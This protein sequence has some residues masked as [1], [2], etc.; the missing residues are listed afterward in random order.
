MRRTG[1]PDGRRRRRRPHDRARS[2]RCG[3]TGSDRSTPI[4]ARSCRVPASS[5]CVA[6]PPR[7]G[8]R[9]RCRHWA[10][11][12]C[13]CARHRRVA[14]AEASTGRRGRAA[15]TRTSA[16]SGRAAVIFT[17][18]IR[19]C[20]SNCSPAKSRPSMARGGRAGAVAGDRP[21]RHRACRGRRAYRWSAAT[22]VA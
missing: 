14:C 4:R 2:D 10:R 3:G 8:A 18:A 6:V 16:R 20:S 17:S 22:S 5:R 12:A 1:R 15:R 21:N 9:A 19:N 7:G 13:R 11:A